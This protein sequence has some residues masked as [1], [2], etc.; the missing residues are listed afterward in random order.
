MNESDDARCKS[1]GTV[2][3]GGAMAGSGRREYPANP[4]LA[5]I[6]CERATTAPN[7]KNP[8]G[9][10]VPLVARVAGSI[11]MTSP[12]NSSTT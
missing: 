6:S 5:T 12:L 7:G 8:T 3:N 2:S 1:S 10:A 9:T 11:A 4:P